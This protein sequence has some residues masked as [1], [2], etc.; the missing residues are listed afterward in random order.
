MKKSKN[1]LIISLIIFF[2]IGLIIITTIFIAKQSA[3]IFATPNYDFT[4]KN[5]DF[6][7]TAD[8]SWVRTGDADFT[9]GYI[10]MIDGNSGLT[11]TLQ[12]DNSIF[13]MSKVEVGDDEFGSSIHC[14]SINFDIDK[15]REINLTIAGNLYARSSGR[16]I[17]SGMLIFGL[18]ESARADSRIDNGNAELHTTFINARKTIFSWNVTDNF[19]SEMKNID[20]LNF[21]VSSFANR[22]R[23][24]AELHISD[25]SVDCED[26]YEYNNS[27]CIEKVVIENNTTCVE[28][29]IPPPQKDNTFLYMIIGAGVF[30]IG[31][32]L[33]ILWR[34]R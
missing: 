5:I 17:D 24:H 9:D 20:N 29:C 32:I 4:W 14:E 31:G 16:N 30:I 26:G 7:C 11:T 3:S 23:S 22:G 2:C 21:D 33:Y 13:L 34:R 10:N 6:Q 12:A 18:L 28:N 25:I 1:I 15:V 8:A 19:K 27:K